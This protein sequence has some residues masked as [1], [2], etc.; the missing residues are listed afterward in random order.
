[1]RLLAAQPCCQVAWWQHCTDRSLLHSQAA[2]GNACYNITRANPCPATPQVL[3]LSRFI[4]VVKTR[5]LNWRLQH[6]YLVADRIED[7]TP[8]HALQE[9]PECDREVVLYGY[10]RGAPLKLGA[11]VHVAGVGDH[12]LQVSWH[13]QC[14]DQR[15]VI[16]YTCGGAMAVHLASCAV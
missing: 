5:P 8:P 12:V 4:S 15:V 11:A 14:S 2:R 6:P 10:L 3:N 1:M 9:S 7:V 13:V 16:Q